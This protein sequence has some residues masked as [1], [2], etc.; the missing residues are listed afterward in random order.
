[1]Q[2]AR[3]TRSA[4]KA[5][6]ATPVSTVAIVSASC[7]QS[8]GHEAA[9]LEPVER[10]LLDRRPGAVGVEADVAEED[11]VGPGDRAF[12]ELDRVRPVEAVGEVAQALADRLGRCAAARSRR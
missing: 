5:R 9:F 1:M 3:S 12:A 7:G 4:S 8:R 10:E 2:S 11:A 6:S